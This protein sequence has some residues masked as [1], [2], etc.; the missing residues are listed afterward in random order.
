MNPSFGTISWQTIRIGVDRVK[1]GIAE[2]REHIFLIEME[3]NAIYIQSAMPY[4]SSEQIDA[5]RESEGLLAHHAALTAHWFKWY[6]NTLAADTIDGWPLIAVCLWCNTKSVQ[7]E[8]KK[9]VWRYH[10]IM[11]ITCGHETGKRTAYALCDDD[12]KSLKLLRAIV[13]THFFSS[14]LYFLRIHCT[15]STVQS[16]ANGN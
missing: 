14:L 7:G 16:V 1:T 6:I 4:L 2:K 10:F 12:N 9:W 11:W 8:E 3:P 5:F 15:M 13:S